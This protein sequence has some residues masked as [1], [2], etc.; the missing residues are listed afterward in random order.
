M[1]HIS[2]LVG[3]KLT[4]IYLFN[5]DCTASRANMVESAPEMRMPFV[6]SYA[7]LEFQDEQ[8]WC[9]EPC[10]VKFDQFRYPSLGLKLSESTTSD[11]RRELWG[12][13]VE[14]A[15][16]FAEAQFHLPFLVADTV[17]SDPMGEEAVSEFQ[18]FDESG[19]FIIFRHVMPP[20]SLGIDLVG[21]A[22]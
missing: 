19:K 11:L 2:V 8:F 17:E 18:F 3:K 7:I 22:E 20:M 13:K 5:Y 16:P 9:I 6:T 14:N 10:E 12:G 15:K 1:P 21:S 4:N